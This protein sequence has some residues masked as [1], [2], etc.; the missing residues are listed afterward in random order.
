MRKIPIIESD[1][2]V[3]LRA[4]LQ[5]C[6]TFNPLTG[7]WVAGGA[8]RAVFEG[9]HTSSDIDL[10]F[11]DRSAAMTAEK[12]FTKKHHSCIS[13]SM[14]K[15]IKRDDTHFAKTIRLSFRG[16]IR[17]VQFIKDTS[18]N[19]LEDLFRKFDFSVCQVATDLEFIYA[20]DEFLVDHRNKTLR[21]ASNGSMGSNT[22]GR[23]FKYINYGFDPVVSL[24][25]YVTDNYD[26]DKEWSKYDY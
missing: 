23:V 18:F 8:A 5:D 3:V 7:P 25:P 26:S 24:I 6:I 1:Y 20:S 19:S 12:E 21:M 2:I 10:F 17:K 22:Y 16:E 14:D 15:S 4:L 11:T 13:M 9:A